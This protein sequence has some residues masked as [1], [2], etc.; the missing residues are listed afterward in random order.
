MCWSAGAGLTE[1]GAGRVEGDALQPIALPPVNSVELQRAVTNAA[2]VTF[3][4]GTTEQPFA[5]VLRYDGATF[6]AVGDLTAYLDPTQPTGGG[7][8]IIG[9]V[10]SLT[11][12][13][14]GA[15]ART[16]MGEGAQASRPLPVHRALAKGQYRRAGAARALAHRAQ[17]AKRGSFGAGHPR[18][19]AHA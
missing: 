5:P 11:V 7:N 12:D 3:V 15:P 6:T 8:I 1:W 17:Q 4:P 10:R 18:S 13:E 16:A 2:G 14:T 19:L 9:D